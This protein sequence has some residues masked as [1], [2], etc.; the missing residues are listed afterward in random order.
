MTRSP[1]AP[2]SH[3]VLVWARKS[4][5]LGLEEVARVLGVSPDG[6]RAWERGSAKPTLRQLEALAS[7]YRRPLGVFF[8]PS[9]PEEPPPPRDFRV[10]PGTGSKPLS[11]RTLLA[12]R[13]A[14]WLRSKAEAMSRDLAEERPSLLPSFRL[15]EPPDEAAAG[16]RRRLEVTLDRQFACRSLYEAFREW[17]SRIEA[18]EILVFQ[19]AIPLDDARGFS[20]RADRF[21]VIVVSSA[22]AVAA[23]VFTL[24]HEY[25]HLGLG[26]PGICIP[27]DGAAEVP[28]R[29]E[30]FCNAFAGS[31]LVPR[32]ALKER[33]SP[34]LRDAL[35]RGE[36]EGIASLGQLFGVSREVLLRRAFDLE[37]VSRR[38]YKAFHDRGKGGRSSHRRA[39][40]GFGEAPPKRCVSERGRRFVSLVL[41]ALDREA[42]TARDAVD[43]LGVK[44]EHIEA[45][46]PHVSS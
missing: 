38:T 19:T 10:L 17:R 18:R 1:E 3:A 7:K 11:H 22:D 6:M 16:E 28:D 40:G 14:H 29:T 26:T 25:A 12:I 20:I 15:S 4:A 21:P 27:D 43:Y 8:L 42:I 39:R 32:D 45:L 24:F 13:R 37:L 34:T 31:L 2:A 36:E 44:T 41:E 30:R 35:E 33:W 9:P 23:R 46:R 5:G